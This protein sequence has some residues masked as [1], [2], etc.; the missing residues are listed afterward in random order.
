M[1]YK[2]LIG[3]NAEGKDCGL[4]SEILHRSGENCEKVSVKI[5]VSNPRFE[6][7]IS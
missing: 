5:A 4:I 6:P 1:I 3:K 2:L 7:I